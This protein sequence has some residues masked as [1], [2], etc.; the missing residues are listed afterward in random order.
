MTT[1]HIPVRVYDLLYK[2][3]SYEELHGFCY[4]NKEFREVIDSIGPGEG[5]KTLIK[6][7][8]AHS[9][10]RSL[11]KELLRFARDTNPQ[12]YEKQGPYFEK[13]NPR[14]LEPINLLNNGR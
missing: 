11:I 13:S 9:E 8:I 14:Y 10:R 2:G 12:R 1:R 7:L 5:R 4:Y 3:F 6:K